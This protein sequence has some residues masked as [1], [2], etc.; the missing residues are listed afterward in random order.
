MRSKLV[1]L[2]IISFFLVTL[3]SLNVTA[4]EWDNVKSYD[5]E[6]KTITIINALGFGKDIAKYRLVENTDNCLIDCYA[7]IE[8]QLMDEGPLAT[9][10]EFKN[11]LGNS[12]E[13]NEFKYFVLRENRE[14][15]LIPIY[16]RQCIL[17]NISDE[18]CTWV[19]TGTKE[20]EV[21][22]YDWQRY[23]GDDLQPGFYTWKIEGRK[24]ATES[25]DWIISA[26]G[27]DLTEW[28]WWGSGWI[29]KKELQIR[30]ETGVTQQDYQVRLNVTYDADMQAD[31]GDLRFVD[32][33]ESTEL[34]YY[35]WNTTS[36]YALVDVRL[37]LT[38]GGNTTAYMYYGNSSVAT[39]S[40]G[41]TT[42]TEMFFDFESDSP[43]TTPPTGWFE[44]AGGTAIV[45]DVQNAAGQ[46][47][48]GS[49]YFRIQDAAG[50]EGEGI[51][52]DFS[53]A[54]TQGKY[55]FY[56]KR[57]AGSDEQQ[58]TVWRKAVHDFSGEYCFNVDQTGVST[59]TEY[60]AQF[61]ASDVYRLVNGGV[62]GSFTAFAGAGDC[63]A[64][65]FGTGPSARQM[66]IYYDVLAFA[67]Y[68]FPEPTSSFGPE[69]EI[70]IVEVNLNE[71][72]D[73]Y[74]STNP[75]VLFNCTSRA[76]GGILN[77]TLI[78]N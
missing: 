67:N 68:T 40:N 1:T 13:I 19:Q 24:E 16:E 29:R 60:Q 18:L 74:N 78:I 47:Y 61:N 6:T 7:I 21:I 17:V 53:A 45:D 52:V 9:E 43:G 41:N 11:K 2:V 8:T 23:K 30:E 59:Y 62:P 38:G 42:Y 32:S 37:N 33:A 15:V 20:E 35:L 69:E 22:S 55:M 26:F 63:G 66:T 3:L 58:L 14:D 5:E 54:Y 64:F 34:S 70:P 73:N 50:G 49:N 65:M 76:S 44:Y 39:T 71:P 46:S 28:A 75:D 12:K 72:I 31:W 77:L 4:W 57:T 56:R 48:Q 27:V 51:G 10:I 25:I 36:A